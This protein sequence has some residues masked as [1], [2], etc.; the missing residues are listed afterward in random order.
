[1]PNDDYGKAMHLPKVRVQGKSGG[2]CTFVWFSFLATWI[3]NKCTASCAYR[4]GYG[5]ICSVEK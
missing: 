3:I 5:F 1:M 4:G 2:K